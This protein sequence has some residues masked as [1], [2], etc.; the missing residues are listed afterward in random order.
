M[1][2]LTNLRRGGTSAI[3]EVH[4]VAS[5]PTA[6]VIQT[7][8]PYTIGW[9]LFASASATAT[10]AGVFFVGFTDIAFPCY[11][12][13]PVKETNLNMPILKCMS[14]RYACISAYSKSDKS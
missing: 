14:L 3:R 8:V 13:L 11:D 7:V 4:L 6:I 12:H 9:L 2:Y 10:G 5:T 1:P